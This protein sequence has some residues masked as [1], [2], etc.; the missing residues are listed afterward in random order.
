MHI[1]IHIS[2][3]QAQV[4]PKESNKISMSVS[5]GEEKARNA[6]EPSFPKMSLEETNISEATGQLEA[7]MV[8]VTGT[9]QT[10]RH[11]RPRHIQLMAFSGAIGTGLFVGSGSA[12]ARAGPLGLFLG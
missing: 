1:Y 11:L 9:K 6:P 8:P 5:K 2:L 12:L 7:S 10:L 4:L 3:S